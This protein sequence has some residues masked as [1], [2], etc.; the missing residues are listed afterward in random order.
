VTWYGESYRLDDGNALA[1]GDFN[2]R[3][4][5]DH[6]DADTHTVTAGDDI[7][8]GAYADSAD[9]TAFVG[10]ADPVVTRWALEVVGGA[11]TLALSAGVD[12]DFTYTNPALATQ[13]LGSF[14]I[15]GPGTVVTGEL[16]G[17]DHAMLAAQDSSIILRVQCTS[18]S[19][20]IAQVK[21]R[22]W[23]AAGASG[24]WVPVGDASTES[25]AVQ[26]RAWLRAPGTEITD[27]FT[28]SIPNYLDYPDPDGARD[29]VMDAQ[30]LAIAQLAAAE[31]ELGDFVQ[32]GIGTGDIAL[33][34]ASGA[35]LLVHVYD[36][37]DH[38][39]YQGEALVNSRPG[40][41]WADMANVS[42]DVSVV[43]IDPAETQYEDEAY[44]R[45]VGGGALVRTFGGWTTGALRAIYYTPDGLTWPTGSAVVHQVTTGDVPDTLEPFVLVTGGSTTSIAAG[46]SGVGSVEQII[47]LTGG[48]RVLAAIQ[49]PGLFAPTESADGLEDDDWFGFPVHGYRYDGRASLLVVDT[50]HLVNFGPVE[51]Y[52]PAAVAIQPRFFVRD[53]DLVDQPVGWGK[54][55]DDVV[56]I[57]PTPMGRYRDMTVAEYA[58]NP[59]PA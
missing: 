53:R 3:D 4:W 25:T 18:G 23:P 41:I 28:G 51:V 8:V 19:V 15:A 47:P 35:S 38:F 40:W 59:P 44:V 33:S 2:A 12:P 45:A 56:F 20:D 11:G 17:I 6:W 27:H 43:G 58:A 29:A 50:G 14:T 46:A 55:S 39:Y 26:R 24:A 48:E 1:G 16:V 13:N 42:P 32:T 10:Y 7:I 22:V 21:L 36:G 34:S 30:P 54:T 37:A 5:Y 49:V 9:Y 52:D 31:G 57:I